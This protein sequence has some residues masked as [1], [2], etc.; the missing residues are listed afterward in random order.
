M[1]GRLGADHHTQTPKEGRRLRRIII[2]GT[3][4]AVLVGATVAYAAVNTYTAKLTFS[5]KAGSKKS[6]APLTVTE[7]LTAA[8]VAGAASR[9]APLID[10][11]TTIYGAVANP[12]PF[13]TCTNTK[14]LLGPKFNLNCPSKS[15]VAT[16][17]VSSLLGGLPLSGAG[18][19][20]KP[21]LVVYNAGGGKLWYFF[22]ASTGTQCAGLKTGQTAPYPG[23]IKQSGKNLVLDVPLPKDVSTSVANHPGLYGSLINE[24][25]HFKKLTTKVKG[26]T[27]GFFSSVACQGKKRPYSVSFT[28][29]P[30]G[31]TKETKVVKG[32]AGC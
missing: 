26:K 12:K 2:I 11:K 13:P 10:I 20:C 8:N 16:G 17:N 27:V 7:N 14:I 23:T 24:V 28:A 29:T 1:S 3:A 18:A 22:T 4:L 31:T 19:S 32:S 5:G 6:P 15:E 30:D 21:G 9:A 25:V